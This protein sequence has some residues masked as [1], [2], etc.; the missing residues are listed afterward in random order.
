MA[1]M[2]KMLQLGLL[3]GGGWLVYS[4]LMQEEEG[5]GETLLDTLLNGGNGNGVSNGGAPPNGGNGSPNGET[6]IPIEENGGA[7]NGTSVTPRPPPPQSRAASSSITDKMGE[8]AGAGPYTFWEWNWFYMQVTGAPD[9]P[10]PEDLGI[11]GTQEM[12]LSTWQGYANQSGLGLSGI[13]LGGPSSGFGLG[14]AA[15][16]SRWERATKEFGV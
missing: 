13:Y 4:Y 7:G 5:T 14:A 2:N 8:M 9:A 6:R 12:S 1:A 15:R 3:A 10:A 11:S 16:A